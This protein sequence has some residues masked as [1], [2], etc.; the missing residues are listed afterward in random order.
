[1]NFLILAAN[2]QIARIVENRILSEDNFQD[3]NL[4][5]GLRTP[6]R[7]CL[8]EPK[9]RMM[10]VDLNNNQAVNKAMYK[11]NIVFVNVIDHTKDNIITK[12]VIKAMKI[13]HV[14]RVIFANILGIY[15]EV[16]GE[17]GRWNHQFVMP[18]LKAAINADKLLARSGLHYTTLRLPWLN[19]HNEIKYSITTHNEPYIGVSGSRK[20]IA[21]AILKIVRNP[22]LYDNDSIG[23]ADPDTQGKDRPVY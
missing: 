13:N 8:L 21:D 22:A 2:G 5:L 6:H 16:G 20:S 14:S 9:A 11:Q 19:D 23:I 15:N 12:N 3:I 10:E 7:L 4:T 18:G 17:F 1:M